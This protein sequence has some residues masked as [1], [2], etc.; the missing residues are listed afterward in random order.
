MVKIAENRYVERD[1]LEDFVRSRH[2]G[3]F[4]TVR[5]NGLPQASP[6]TMGL[7]DGEIV[8]ATYPERSKVFNLRSNPQASMVVLSEA[9]ND[10][11]VQ[12]NGEAT[13]VELPEAV[14]GLV[15]YFRAISGE[16]S[17]W[18]EYREA[19]V[20]QGKCLIRLSIDDWGPIACGGFPPRLA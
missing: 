17:D 14:E 3:V 5:A 7:Q 13:V 9:F 8:I 11:W 6:V 12:I 18:D 19:M 1:E 15:G 16:H 4:L 2:R 20:K 10:E